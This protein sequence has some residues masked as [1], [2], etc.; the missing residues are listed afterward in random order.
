MQSDQLE[1]QLGRHNSNS[2]LILSLKAP[3]PTKPNTLSASKE[4]QS[5]KK[6]KVKETAALRSVHPPRKTKQQ[7]GFMVLET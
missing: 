2:S 4:K 1:F 5:Q 6:N 3:R 7:L